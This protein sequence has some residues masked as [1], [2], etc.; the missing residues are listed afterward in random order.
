MRVSWDRYFM[1]L[2]AQAA[3]RSTCPRKHVG[4]IIVRDKTVLST[5]Y[6][7]SLRG[8]SH[9]TEVGCLMVNGHCIRTVHAEANALVQA[10]RH[11][12]RLEGAEIYVTAS[13]CFD[14]FKLIVNAGLRTVYFGEFYRDERVLEFADELGISMVNLGM[15]P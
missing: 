12:T 14:C 6:N 8:A 10:A 13:P 11:G 15:E 4:A 7:G 1:N 3:T 5:G 2:A 9:C